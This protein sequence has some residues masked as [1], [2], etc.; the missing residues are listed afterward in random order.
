MANIEN[1]LPPILIMCE[2]WVNDNI[3]FVQHNKQF[4]QEV[5][6][7]QTILKQTLPPVLMTYVLLIHSFTEESENETLYKILINNKHWS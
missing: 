7:Y 4:N 2:V 5:V 3:T 6:G 1:T